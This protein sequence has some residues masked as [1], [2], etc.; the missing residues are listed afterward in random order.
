MKY[1]IDF[2]RGRNG[3]AL[4]PMEF[5]THIYN[6]HHR[7]AFFHLA[8]NKTNYRFPP[9]FGNE[10]VG[11]WTCDHHLGF[12]RVLFP[13]WWLFI[14]QPRSFLRQKKLS[15][16]QSRRRQLF[17]KSQQGSSTMNT[18]RAYD[19]DRIVNVDGDGEQKASVLESYTL[20]LGRSHFSG[21]WKWWWIRKKVGI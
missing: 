14:E 12:D 8:H 10:H 7:V 11:T 2:V 20:F 6:N 5:T 19:A 16:L 3:K 1:S 13:T 9:F 4:I 18:K 15:F 21:N 17:L